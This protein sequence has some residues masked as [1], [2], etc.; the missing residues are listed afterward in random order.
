MNL[1]ILPAVAAALFLAAEARSQ[2]DAEAKTD[3]LQG[4]WKLMYTQDEKHVEPGCEQSRMIVRADGR[5]VFEVAAHTM[6]RGAL[7]FGNSGKLKSLDLKLADGQT[8]LGVYEQKGDDLVVCFAEA[9]QERPAGTSPK[10]TQWAET[11]KRTK[12]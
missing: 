11:W 12:P 1:R 2:K 7:T 10:G 9:G 4:E 5:V 3:P 8:L 6:N